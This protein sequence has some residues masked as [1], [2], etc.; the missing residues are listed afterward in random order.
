MAHLNYAQTYHNSKGMEPND[1]GTGIFMQ[2]RVLWRLLLLTA[3]ACIVWGPQINIV[4]GPLSVEPV[5]ATGGGEMTRVKAALLGLG[6][7][8][9]RSRQPTNMPAGELK[10]TP[11]GMDPDFGARNEAPDPQAQKR[12]AQCRDYIARFAPVAVAEMNKFGIPA[13]IILAQGLLESNAGASPLARRTQNHFGI[14]C[15]SK[16]CKRG[17]C[18]N[19]ADDSH[20]DFF[21]RYPNAWGSYRAHSLFLKNTPRYARLFQLP[22]SDYQNWARGLAKSGYASDKQYGEKL[23][24]IIQNLKLHQYD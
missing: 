12:L 19:F 10:T 21:V 1:S 15:F 14:K 9:N 7:P 4:I 24:A 23:I 5:E 18:I 2:E 22:G 13:S 6:S 17:H 16:R 8:P 20:K 3:I 11:L